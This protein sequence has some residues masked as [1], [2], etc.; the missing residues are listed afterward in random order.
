MGKSTIS[1]AIFNSFLYVYQRVSTLPWSMGWT[2]RFTWIYLAGNDLTY[3]NS[4][5]GILIRVSLKIKNDSIILHHIPEYW[6]MNNYHL[7]QLTVRPKPAELFWGYVPF[8]SLSGWASCN[9]MLCHGKVAICRWAVI[10]MAMAFICFH[11]YNCEQL[12]EV[13]KTI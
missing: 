5:Y 11:G 7:P 10:S 6:S 8:L 9:L 2:S 13:T 12:P 3:P 1:M 4:M